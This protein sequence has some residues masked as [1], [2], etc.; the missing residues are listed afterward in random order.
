MHCGILSLP[1]CHAGVV[2]CTHRGSGGQT[3]KSADFD[4]NLNSVNFSTPSGHASQKRLTSNF[5]VKTPDLRLRTCSSRTQINSYCCPDVIVEVKKRFFSKDQQKHANG[6]NE[7]DL[8]ISPSGCAA[9]AKGN[10]ASVHFSTVGAE[11]RGIER[12]ERRSGD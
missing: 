4:Q 5:P 1:E 12:I 8:V 7:P 6:S 10:S 2:W 9:D 3:W 11:N